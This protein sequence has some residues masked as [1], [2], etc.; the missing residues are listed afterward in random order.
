MIILNAKLLRAF[1]GVALL[2]LLFA[3]CEINGEGDDLMRSSR[4][5]MKTGF[6]PKRCAM[7]PLRMPIVILQGY[8]EVGD[9]SI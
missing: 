1:L 8:Q 4:I 9:L 6:S 2:L 3:A 5:S 7:F